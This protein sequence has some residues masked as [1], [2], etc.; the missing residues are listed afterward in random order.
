MTY[1]SL[2]TKLIYFPLLLFCLFVFIPCKGDSREQLSTEQTSYVITDTKKIE[3][4]IILVTSI[5]TLAGLI[6]N[7]NQKTRFGKIDLKLEE[8][9]VEHR[10]MAKQ[11]QDN[12]EKITSELK[13]L[14][15]LSVKTDIIEGFRQITQGYTRMGC[16]TK[17]K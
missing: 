5:I 8:N 10:N 2:K 15:D 17:I 14:A 9:F 6:L 4:L 3:G 1:L 13:T 12:Y 7:Y 16:D 11:N